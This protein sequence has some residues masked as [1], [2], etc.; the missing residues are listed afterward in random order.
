M[1]AS[2]ETDDR[3]YGQL[4]PVTAV[5]CARNAGACGAR[6]AWLSSH[7]HP[8]E[9]KRRVGARGGPTLWLGPPQA[10][11]RSLSCIWTSSSIVLP[12]HI[13]PA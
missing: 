7:V 9:R 12:I 6:R 11:A 5:H 4:G 3:L 13:C 1:V 2:S 8:S 10:T